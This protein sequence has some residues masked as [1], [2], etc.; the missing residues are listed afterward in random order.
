MIEKETG[1]ELARI[2]SEAG[3]PDLERAEQLLARVESLPDA[4]DLIASAEA[5]RVFLKKAQCSLSSQNRA[6]AITAKARRK[7]GE[8]AASLERKMGGGD[9][10]EVA[11]QVKT[12][13]QEASEETGVDRRTL[14]NWQTLAKQTSDA[15]IE[16]AANTATREGREFT[17]GEMMNREKVSAALTAMKPDLESRFAHFDVEL[18]RFH[19][20]ISKR[21]PDPGQAWQSVPQRVR[22]KNRRTVAGS[23]CEWFEKLKE[24]L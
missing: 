9:T 14:H 22:A 6:A 10:R 17:T 5:L 16:A 13:L 20:V 19:E 24:A 1:M 21:Y 3:L 15:E 4:R 8:I 2:G 18:A 23:L 7:G 11:S 12:P